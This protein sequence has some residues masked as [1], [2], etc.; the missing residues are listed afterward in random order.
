MRKSYPLKCHENGGV[1]ALATTANRAVKCE[2]LI[3]PTRHA[4]TAGYM[5]FSFSFKKYT[6]QLRE[7]RINWTDFHNI[8]YHMVDV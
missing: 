3:L 1:V 6:F 4:R 2:P 8:F 7:L 5:L